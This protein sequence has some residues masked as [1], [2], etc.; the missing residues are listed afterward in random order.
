MS[1][2]ISRWIWA[3]CLSVT[4][5][6]ACISLL[7]AQSEK[8]LP[9]ERTVLSDKHQLDKEDTWTLDFRFKN[10]RIITADVP[11]R[12]KKIIWYMWYQVINR[13]GEPRTFIPDIEL[14]TVDKRTVHHDEIL[15]AV[16]EVIRR[17]EDPTNRM[18]IL[19]SVT[20][21]NKPI[22][23]T[24]K[25]S[26]PKAVTGVAIWSDVFDRAPDTSHFTIFVA[27]LSNG[28]VEVDAKTIRRK[29][30]Q[31]NFRRDSDGRKLDS[32]YIRLVDNPGP[33]WIYRSSQIDLESKDREDK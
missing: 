29:T 24:E 7:K 32:D 10:P 25:D 12:G 9:N 14:Y 23:V 28:A 11:G 27:G 31:I 4:T 21:F 3:G 33:E 26:L 15:P 17:I 18:N 2:R 8:D 6:L 20:I 13:T 30:L 16:Q 19:N 22:P 1:R 5:M